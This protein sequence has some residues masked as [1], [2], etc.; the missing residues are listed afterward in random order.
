MSILSVLVG[1]GMTPS[2]PKLVQVG[3]PEVLSVLLDGHVVGFIP[4]DLVEKA[5]S[6]LRRLKLSATSGVCFSDCFCL[7]SISLPGLKSQC[8]LQ[9]PED[10]EVGYVPLSL[11]GAYPGLYLFTS[12]SRF[13]QPV[14]NISVASEENSDIELIGPL[15]QVLTRCHIVTYMFIHIICFF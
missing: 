7:Y 4:S 14:Q 5:V 3:P 13:V 12:P 15:E 8:L 6:H 1:V 10:L 11:G 9:I 2:L